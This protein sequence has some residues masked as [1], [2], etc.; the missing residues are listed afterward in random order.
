MGKTLPARHYAHWDTTGL[1]L[2][3]WGPRSDADA[4]MN[5]TLNRTRTVFY[6]AATTDTP[7][8]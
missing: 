3:D 5:A 2:T 1:Y 4:A 7:R 8:H 6:T